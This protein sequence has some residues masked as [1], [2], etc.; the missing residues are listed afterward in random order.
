MRYKKSVFRSLTLVT[1]LGFSVITPIF[2]CVWFG[3]SIDR[4]LGLN[5]I[6]IFLIIGTMAGGKC[7]Y[8]M[9][10]RVLKAEAMDDQNEK[11]KDKEQNYSTF[12]SKPK[13]ASRVKAERSG[14]DSLIGQ[15]ESGGE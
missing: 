3:Y 2:L 6:V 12:V 13:P 9:V 4:H 5:T 14:E 7:A 11:N 8:E 10:K 1:Q 15:E